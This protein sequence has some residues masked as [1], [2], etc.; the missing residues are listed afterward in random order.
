M[1]CTFQLRFLS[2]DWQ[3]RVFMGQFRFLGG[4][5]FPVSGDI[6]LKIGHANV[7][8]WTLRELRQLLHT[9]PIGTILQIQ[10]YR[11]FIKIP[12]RWQTALMNIPELKG[13]T[14]E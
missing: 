1:K 6:L 12:N 7:L 4:F 11:D 3:L 2:N 8:G 13:P 14:T 9:A 5:F 10:V